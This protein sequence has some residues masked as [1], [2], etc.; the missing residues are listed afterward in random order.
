PPLEVPFRGSDLGTEKKA[1]LGGLSSWSHSRAFPYATLRGAG[2][3]VVASAYPGGCGLR[4]FRPTTG[5]DGG[6]PR[7]DRCPPQL[8]RARAR[9]QRQLGRFASEE[10][11]PRHLGDRAHRPRDWAFVEGKGSSRPGC[12]RCRTLP[13]VPRTPSSAYNSRRGT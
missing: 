7:K 1:P 5:R 8:G 13:L 9:T 12:G 6:S 11:P 2:S 3:L 4:R 10:S